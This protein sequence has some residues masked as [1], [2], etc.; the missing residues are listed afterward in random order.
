MRSIYVSVT[1]V[2]TVRQYQSHEISREIYHLQ[3]E[4]YLFFMVVGLQFMRARHIDDAT[5]T[6]IVNKF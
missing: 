4:A 2:L 5:M 1:Q 6:L 3:N